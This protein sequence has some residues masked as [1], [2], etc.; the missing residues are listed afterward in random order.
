MRRQGREHYTLY[1]AACHQANGQGLAGQYPPLAGSE[2]VQGEGPNRVVRIVL[3]AIA[4]SIDV[5]GLHFDSNAMPPWKPVLS[6]DQIAAILTYVRSEWGNK[7]PP[8]TAE[9]AKKIRDL[10]KDRE[11]PWSA[12]E[13]SKIPEKD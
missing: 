1:C 9:Q 13:L 12:D 6:D 2:W 4:G 3:N 8:V 11:T 5:K 10:E 7:A